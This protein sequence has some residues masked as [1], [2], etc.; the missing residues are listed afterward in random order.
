MNGKRAVGAER[1]YRSSGRESS[2]GRIPRAYRGERNPGGLGRRKPLRGWET[3][4]AERTGRGKPGVS[5]LP[6][7]QTLKGEKPHERCLTV[8]SEVFQVKTL[9]ER[10]TVR[11]DSAMVQQTKGQEFWKDPRDQT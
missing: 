6:S 4:R 11:E 2:E 10:I 8:S 3:L 7:P 5:R 9:K 1:P